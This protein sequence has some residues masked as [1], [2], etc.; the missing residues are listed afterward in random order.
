MDR[1]RDIIP[2]SYTV[3]QTEDF[4]VKAADYYHKYLIRQRNRDSR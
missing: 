3:K 1:L 2:E 4:L